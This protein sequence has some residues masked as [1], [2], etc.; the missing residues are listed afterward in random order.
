MDIFIQDV[1]VPF[2]GALLHLYLLSYRAAIS[3]SRRNCKNEADQ[4]LS[5]QVPSD[6]N[7]VQ[8]RVFLKD[9]LSVF[10]ILAFEVFKKAGNQWALVTVATEVNGNRFIKHYQVKEKLLYNGRQLRCK[11][12]NKKAEALRIMSLLDKEE[13]LRKKAV[14]PSLPKQPRLSRP[15][16]D[17]SNMMTGVWDYNGLGDLVFDLKYKDHRRGTVI[18][19]KTAL[20]VYLES[21]KGAATKVDSNTRIDIPYGILEHTIPSPEEGGHGSLMLTLKSPPKMYRIVSAETLHLYTGTEASLV[22]NVP[23]ISALLLGVSLSRQRERPLHRLCALQNHRDKTAALCMVFKIQFRKVQTMTSAWQFIKDFAVSGMDL[24]R[25]TIPSTRTQTIEKDYTDLNAALTSVIGPHFTF[26]IA[27]Q[28]MA[29]VLEGT[30]TPANMERLVPGVYSLAERYGVA[31]TAAGVGQLA[32]QIPTP[33][34]NINGDA[35]RTQA[36]I[37]MVEMNILEAQ[38]DP[39]SMSNHSKQKKHQHLALTYKATITPTGLVVRGPEWG[40]SNRVLRKYSKHTECFMRV[41][42]ADEDGLSVFHDPRSS[43][44]EVYDRFKNVLRDGVTIAGRTF[45]F[46][47]FSH[48]SL[49]YHAAWFMAPFEEDGITIRAKDV[50][51]ALGDFSNIHCSAKCAARIGQAFSDTVHAIRVPDDAYVVETK[52]DVVKNGRTFSDGCGTISEGLL[53]RVWRSL[54]QNRRSKRPTVLQIRYRGAKGVVSLDKALLGEQLHVRKSMTK[55]VAREGWR[56]LELC[57]AAYRP[58]NM[59]L[60]HQFIKILEDLQVPLRNFFSVQDDAL[61]ALEMVVQHP[62]NAASFLG[63]YLQLGLRNIIFTIQ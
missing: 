61:Q 53:Q 17:F 41:F 31:K 14:Q 62:L 47:G 46:L 39:R 15:H 7:H 57:G 13:E 56:D 24:R 28:M 2:L 4:T 34:P 43:Q 1:S 30:V 40:V 58:L 26:A 29:L 8:L 49:R 63:V 35:Y 23:D 51:Q 22:P 33:A 45:Q 36:L 48:A 21:Q 3:N 16:F 32:Q 59:Y 6:I 12:S 37:N 44:E 10:D 60:N 9:R 5:N 38:T 19:G 11:R 25:I 18:F 27:Y 52:E 50:I 20:V 42:F 55:Y 54:P